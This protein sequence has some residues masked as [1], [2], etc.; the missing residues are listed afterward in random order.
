[1]PKVSWGKPKVN[2]LAALF[3]TYRKEKRMT[4]EQI[5]KLLGV[6]AVSVRAQMNK[7]AEKWRIGDLKLYCEALGIPI[8]DA[9]AAAIQK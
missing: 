8:E 9:L 6:S 5:G 7:D 3:R 4:S 1:M 2:Y